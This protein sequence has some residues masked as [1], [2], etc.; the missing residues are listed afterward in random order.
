MKSKL[1]H[2]FCYFFIFFF[3][4]RFKGIGKINWEKLWHHSY[5][6]NE[7]QIATG[8]FECEPMEKRR[9]GQGNKWNI[10]LFFLFSTLHF[11]SFCRPLKF[12]SDSLGIQQQRERDSLKPKWPALLI[13]HHRVR[14]I[15][16]IQSARTRTFFSFGC[17][18]KLAF[19]PWTVIS[20]LGS[21]RFHS[22][23]N[24]CTISSGRVS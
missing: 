9:K 23:V 11:R 13:L 16:S 22:R 8:E 5:H 18:S 19:P 3:L 2:R 24:S 10:Y 17:S 12:G 6:P 1:C 15:K 14:Y 20:S 7:Q 21:S 4:Y